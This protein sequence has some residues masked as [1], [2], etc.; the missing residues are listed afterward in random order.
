M[1][2]ALFLFLLLSQ[3]SAAAAA[4][5]VAK[6]MP[7]DAYDSV[8]RK[9]STAVLLAL[10][11]YLDFFTELKPNDHP[12]AFW[13]RL[14]HILSAIIL[15]GGLIFFRLLSRPLSE[16]KNAQNEEAHLLLSR[17]LPWFSTWC[18]LSSELKFILIGTGFYFVRRNWVLHRGHREWHILFGLKMVFSFCLFFLAA[19]STGRRAPFAWFRRHL[20]QVL[21]VS[22]VLLLAIV[23]LASSLRFYDI[24]HGLS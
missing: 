6:T 3:S 2:E 8:F 22:C 10:F 5:V 15:G 18:W 11:T 20:H 13:C 17:Q 23:Y 12:V 14:A 24:V 19:A 21:T 16:I 1:S 7:S 4:A 9:F